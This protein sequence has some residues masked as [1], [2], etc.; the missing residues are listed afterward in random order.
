[1][2]KD[3]TEVSE[4]D[5]YTI[6]IGAFPLSYPHYGEVV[7]QTPAAD[8][9]PAEWVGW[10]VDIKYVNDETTYRLD[11]KTLTTALHKIA[12]DKDLRKDLRDNC[13]RLAWPTPARLDAVDIDDN[14]ADMIIQHATLG[15]VAFT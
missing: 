6:I 4:K 3:E 14:L 9:P 12:R 7:D 11:Y 2:G 10:H 8:A 1:M 13:A 5:L 15:R